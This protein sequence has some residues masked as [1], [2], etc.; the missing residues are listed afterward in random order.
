[1]TLNINIAGKFVNVK[2]IESA[3]GVIKTGYPVP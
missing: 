3:G 1:M 2:V